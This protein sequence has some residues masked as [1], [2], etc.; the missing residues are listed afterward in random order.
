[1]EIY[2]YN[3]KPSEAIFGGIYALMERSFPKS[4]RRTE[5]DLRKEFS[6]AEFRC[7]CVLEQGVSGFLNYWDFGALIYA[8]HFAVDPSLRGNGLGSRM[9]G[10]LI[11]RAEGRRVILEAEPAALGDVAKRRIAFYERLGFS[12]NPYRYVQPPLSEGQPPVELVIM[13]T[14]GVM[15]EEE[16]ALAK[17]LLYERVYA[18]KELPRG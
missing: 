18:G 15:P 4:E 7:A 13:S 2:S 1:M 3:N 14:G 5:N 12:V 8:E 6:E 17:K 10:E 11:S 9:M 16:F